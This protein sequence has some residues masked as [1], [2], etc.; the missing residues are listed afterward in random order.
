M[1]F[2]SQSTLMRKSMTTGERGLWLLAAAA[3]LH[4]GEEYV[5]DWPAWAHARSGLPVDWRAFWVFNG[6]FLLLALGAAWLGWRRPALS[7][8]LPALTTINAVFFHIGPTALQ[9]VLSPGTVTSI[10][11]YLPL[12]AWIYAAAR[13]EG[14]LT[15]RAALISTTIGAVIMGVPALLLSMRR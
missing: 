3:V 9:G 8:S 4:V 6:A 2:N 7:L 12:A 1:F 5:L 14:V 11:L 13:R 15:A 10:V